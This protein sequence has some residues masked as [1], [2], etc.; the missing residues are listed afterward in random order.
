MRSSVGKFTGAFNVR[1]RFPSNLFE[2]GLKPNQSYTS[3]FTQS[4]HPLTTLD[5]KQFSTTTVKV[6]SKP[7]I[8]MIY[9][10]HN[11][12]ISRRMV[13]QKMDW[14]TKIG[15]DKYALEEP[16]ET[17]SSRI[18]D[19]NEELEV[20]KKAIKNF[21]LTD[22]VESLHEKDMDTLEDDIAAK[23]PSTSRDI[24]SMLAHHI[25]IMPSREA[26]I[27]MYHSIQNLAKKHNKADSEIYY[28]IDENFETLQ[29]CEAR[30]P[31]GMTRRNK[32]MFDKLFNIGNYGIISIIGIG[33][34]TDPEGY[35]LKDLLE[36][37]DKN[38]VLNIYPFSRVVPA[39]DF[40]AEL[41]KK[42]L[43]TPAEKHLPR[44]LHAIDMKDP[45]KF[46][47]QFAIIAD[48][49]TS[50]IPY[51]TKLPSY[52]A[53]DTFNKYA[54]LTPKSDLS[55]T[56]F[57]RQGKKEF[58]DAVFKA[59]SPK[60]LNEKSDE[61]SKMRIPHIHKVLENGERCLVFERLDK[62]A[63]AVS[64]TKGNNQQRSI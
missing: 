11:D 22:I 35:G 33:H 26:A 19:F 41:R 30:S 14:F 52:P 16:P 60:I 1:S 32:H 59:P 49:I 10:F 6:R 62:F 50:R 9:D 61:L 25:A 36:I 47:Q 21:K 27:S 3:R 43:Y 56:P 15:Y 18:R 20:S 24:V 51:E 17:L 8:L 28:P 38:N 7:P 64:K 13:T 31:V 4:N 53:I 37:E 48:L 42:H 12:P 45:D 46:E 44:R 23:L 39:Y 29:A 63:Q 55:F 54:R 58:V 57:S 5:D 40:E 2:N 34:Y